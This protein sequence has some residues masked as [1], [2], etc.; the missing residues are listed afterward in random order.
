MAESETILKYVI[1]GL[2]RFDDNPAGFKTTKYDQEDKRLMLH[3]MHSG[4]EPCGVG[5]FV[6]DCKTGT[7]IHQTNCF[8]DDGEYVWSD[9]D[10]YHVLK[11][12]AAVDQGFIDHVKASL[13]RATDAISSLKEAM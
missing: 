8:Y 5:G 9:Q 6:D 10:A 1:D 7:I 3:Y 12:D 13:R 2:T 4:V 11:Y